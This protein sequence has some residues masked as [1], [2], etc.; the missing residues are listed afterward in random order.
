MIWV[1]LSMIV[2]CR[3]FWLS[4]EECFIA[5]SGIP[6]FFFFLC[7]CVQVWPVYIYIY[8]C[9]YIYTYVYIYIHMYIYMYMYMYIY[10]YIHVYIYVYIFMYI[11]IYINAIMIGLSI[12]AK[13][14]TVWIQ[15]GYPQAASASSK[16]ACKPPER[17]AHRK[18]IKW[19]CCVK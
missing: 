12:P 13:V 1:T 3:S 6:S 9:V 19:W 5:Y 16:G 4:V 7:V 11:Y 15:N 17:M 10:I 14:Q 8:I 2:W 18:F